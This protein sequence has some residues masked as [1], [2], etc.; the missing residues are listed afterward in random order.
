LHQIE[1]LPGKGEIPVTCQ[2][3]T[4]GMTPA[5]LIWGK[6]NRGDFYTGAV[7]SAPIHSVA[8]LSA[9]RLE[10]TLV[11]S[12]EVQLF[13]ARRNAR[14]LLALRSVKILEAGIKGRVS[15]DNSAERQTVRVPCESWSFFPAA[16]L[17]FRLSIGFDQVSAL[18]SWLSWG[19]SKELSF[20]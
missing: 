17:H 20:D 14:N 4:G 18:R 19:Q 7:Q 11:Q 12:F 15:D 5:N 16:P 9:E 10:V 2:I 13:K 1:I 8:S 6:G 3:D